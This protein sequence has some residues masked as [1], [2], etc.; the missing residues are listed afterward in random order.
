[1]TIDSVRPSLKDRVKQATNGAAS[2]AA[3]DVTRVVDDAAD[4]P[5]ITEVLSPFGCPKGVKGGRIGLYI[6]NDRLQACLSW[7]EVGQICFVPL[8]RLS[9]ALQVIESLLDTSDV[10]WLRDRASKRV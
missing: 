2:G 8:D 6:H 10:K 3:G 9:D 7:P 4:F 5:C 1:M